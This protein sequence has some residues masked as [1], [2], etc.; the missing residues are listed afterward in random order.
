MPGCRQALVGDEIGELARI[1]PTG[2][3]V[4]RDGV[5]ELV[6]DEEQF[7]LRAETEM[8]ILQDLIVTV[9]NL[10]AELKVESRVKVPIE[11]K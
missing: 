11:P 6:P 7:D 1:Y 4:V 5:A 9:R 8:A 2:A 3:V 10:R